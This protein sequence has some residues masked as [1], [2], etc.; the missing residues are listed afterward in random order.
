M[1]FWFVNRNENDS[2]PDPDPDFMVA[3]HVNQ[4]VID[5]QVPWTGRLKERVYS[6][7]YGHPD[8]QRSSLRSIHLGTSLS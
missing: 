1:I 8:V 5:P 6:D 2:E 4:E 7:Q 3:T